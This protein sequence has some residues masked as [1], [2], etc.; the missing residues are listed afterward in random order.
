[1]SKEEF[2]ARVGYQIRKLRLEKQLS[3]EKLALEAGMEYTQV[4]RIELGR[5]NTSIYQ[6]YKISKSLDVTIPEIFFG[7]HGFN[8]NNSK[9]ISKSVPLKKREVI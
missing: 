1:M 3:I 5:I 2:C 4:S 9:K 7:I 6:I 8:L